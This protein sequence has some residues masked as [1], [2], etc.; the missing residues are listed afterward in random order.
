MHGYQKIK[1][2]IYSMYETEI[3]SATLTNREFQAENS[4]PYLHC[5]RMHH[6][7]DLQ[8]QM[9]RLT[10]YGLENLIAYFIHML[11]VILPGI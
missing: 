9:P 6:G 7:M 1:Y 2:N 3:N 10:W 5:V 11:K 4:K 8:S